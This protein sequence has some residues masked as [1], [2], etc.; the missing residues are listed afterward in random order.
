MPLAVTG[1]QIHR[2]RRPAAFPAPQPPQEFS[3]GQVAV[4][5][6]EQ[7]NGHDRHA[8]ATP[9]FEC[10]RWPVGQAMGEPERWRVHGRTLQW[11]T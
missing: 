8:P 2:R 6:R 1:T 7:T 3:E 11:R 4:L 9:Q 10:A 5:L